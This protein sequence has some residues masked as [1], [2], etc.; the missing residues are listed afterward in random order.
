M[1]I[2]I[3]ARNLTMLPEW[4]GKIDEELC[5]IDCHY[6]GLLHHFRLTLSGTRH[7]KLGAFEIHI[8]GTVPEKTIVVKKKGELVLPL[9]VESFDVLDSELREHNRLRQQV[10]REEPGPTRGFIT[11]IFPEENYGLILSAEGREVYFHK[12][13]VKDMKFEKLNIGDCVEFGEE[14]GDKG[15]QATW[16][17]RR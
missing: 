13:A 2:R 4:D 11:H 12:N 14:A 5:K 7:H 16:V 6:P 10:V 8:T 9:I 15:P 17:R 1:D 3:E